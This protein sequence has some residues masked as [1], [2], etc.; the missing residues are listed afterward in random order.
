MVWRYNKLNTT[1]S[2]TAHER[3][4]GYQTSFERG[5]GDLYDSV[6]CTTMP[7]FL[8][9]VIRIQYICLLIA[10]HLFS[11]YFNST[12][13]SLF[14]LSGIETRSRFLGLIPTIFTNHSAAL[15]PQTHAYWFHLKLT[16]KWYVHIS[17]ARAT[18][19]WCK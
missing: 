18:A 14:F 8:I 12:E 11:K 17:G 4:K 5:D 1:L 3:S 13:K 6:H 7:W 16:W 2:T 10:H 15:P 19:I 9:F